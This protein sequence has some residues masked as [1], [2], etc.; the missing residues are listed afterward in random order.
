MQKK[1]TMELC[2]GRHEID[3]AVDG[4]VFPN[5]LDPLDILTMDAIASESIGEIDE[6][7]LYVTGLSVAL[8][9]VINHCHDK[10]VKL[11][12]FH[13]DRNSGMYYSQP[14]FINTSNCT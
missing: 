9:S 6:L 13:Y 14:V 4:A 12:L 8:V 3:A 10:G 11:T 2:K 7:D 5:E 1:K